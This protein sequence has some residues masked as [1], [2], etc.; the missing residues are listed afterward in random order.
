MFQ[1]VDFYAAA[2]SLM[3]I[4]FF[5]VVA[6]V[7]VYGAGRLAGNVRDMT[8]SEPNLYIQVC[9]W[10]A[11]PCLIM[12][13]WIFSL[14]DYQPPTYNNGQY[15]YPEWS[16]ALGWG[17]AMVSLLAIPTFAMIALYKAKGDGLSQ[18]FILCFS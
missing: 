9:W 1:L 15:V 3:Y 18:V 11:S 10:V 8:G 13:I 2:L 7:W 4:A 5:E 16:I 17:I 12:A 6:V 14:A